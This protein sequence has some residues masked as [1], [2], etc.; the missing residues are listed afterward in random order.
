LVRSSYK[1]E[2]AVARYGLELKS[3]RV[4]GMDVLA[5]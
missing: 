2:E 3:A 1:A 4:A 5:V